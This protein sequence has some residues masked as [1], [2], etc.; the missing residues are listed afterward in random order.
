MFLLNR[1]ND[2]ELTNY[3]RQQKWISDA[4]IVVTVNKTGEG[5]MNCVLRVDTGKRTLVLK[6]SRG[7][8]EKYPHIAAPAKRTLTEGLF[9][10]TISSQSG[11]KQMMPGLIGLD[12]QNNILALEDLGPANDFTYLYDLKNKLN[13]NEIT[14]LVVYLHE[15]HSRVKNSYNENLAN[16]EMRLLN[17]EH[18]FDYPF[19]EDN[20]FDLD[21]IQTGL[22]AKAMPYKKDYTLKKKLDALGSL[23]LSDG[24]YLLHGD[25]YPGSWL[26]TAEGI[27]IIDTE[28]CF[29]GLREF[30]LGVLLAHLNLTQH[31]ETVL[32]AVKKSY[33]A[34]NELDVSVLNGFTG[35]EIM[36]RIIGL[37]Q[38]PLPL[39]LSEKENLLK[40]AS[41]LILQ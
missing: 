9:Y 39:T 25:F 35:A 20:G 22:Q 5:N 10:R 11:I 8:V 34:F 16:R 31:D 27:K 36:R 23:Y 32:T 2:K 40:K 6:Q 33:P 3:L 38:L 24:E 18:I 29:Y 14:C 21:T 26:K 37:A 28:F 4:E 13:N 30:D 15:L 12:E 17:H 7:Y 19:R 41:R 1:D